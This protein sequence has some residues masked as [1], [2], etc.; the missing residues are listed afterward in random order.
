MIALL[1]RILH[2]NKSTIADEVAYYRSL[3]AYME[4]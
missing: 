3:A 2:R 1:R 4:G